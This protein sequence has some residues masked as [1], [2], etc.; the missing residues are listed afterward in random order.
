VVDEAAVAPRIQPHILREERE[1]LQSTDKRLSRSDGT[2]AQDGKTDSSIS[3]GF[4][5]AAKRRSS[6]S[7]FVELLRMALSS[8]GAP[9]VNNVIETRM[10]PGHGDGS[11]YL[12]C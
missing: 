8:E 4:R 11:E 5:V 3:S 10:G 6:G 7:S 2:D 1:S 9:I 12:P